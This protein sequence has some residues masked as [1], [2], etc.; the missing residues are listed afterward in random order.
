VPRL[1]VTSPAIRLVEIE[2]DELEE[3]IELWAENIGESYASVQRIGKA[4]D[5]GRD[6]VAFLTLQ[7][8]EGAWH[9]YQCKRKTR[10]SKLGLPEALGE[11]G[12]L[13]FHH[14]AGAY[15][16]L[17]TKYAF[18]TP[19]G[20]VGDLVHLINHPSQLRDALIASWND[21]CAKKITARQTVPLTS[22][23]RAAINGYDF[24]EIEYL[25]AP[26]S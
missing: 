4:N 16:T 25:A 24:G 7:K 11:L 1:A 8:H 5:K 18:V 26:T 23:I 10:G 19:R 2:D 20:A 14:C 13:F 12:K 9:L 21:H 17:P 3:F 15:A 6:V 22:E